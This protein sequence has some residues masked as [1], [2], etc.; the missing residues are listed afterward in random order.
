MPGLL[1]PIAAPCDVLPVSVALRMVLDQETP[2]GSLSRRHSSPAELSSLTAWAPGEMRLCSM[3]T[4]K[5]S[6]KGSQQWRHIAWLVFLFVA[7]DAS[8]SLA[9]SRAAVR[10]QMCAPLVIGAKNALSSACGMLLAGLREGPV[11]VRQ[12]LDIRRTFKARSSGG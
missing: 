10:G 3:S 9:V 7:L 4:S 2:H 6:S 11:G 1:D 8:K 5:A 12:C